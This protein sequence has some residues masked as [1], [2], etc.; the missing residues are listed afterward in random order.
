[1][2]GRYEN[3]LPPEPVGVFLR[4]DDVIVVRVAAPVGHGDGRDQP[5]AAEQ[6]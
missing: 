2:A 5:K 1:M 6:A 4:F 3:A